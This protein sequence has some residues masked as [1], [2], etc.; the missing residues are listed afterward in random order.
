MSSNAYSSQLCLSDD[1]FTKI[2]FSTLMGE[3]DD[4]ENLMMH[5]NMSLHCTSAPTHAYPQTVRIQRDIERLWT[6]KKD[7]ELINLILM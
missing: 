2:S 5:H 4:K 3:L 1:F 7:E 6:N